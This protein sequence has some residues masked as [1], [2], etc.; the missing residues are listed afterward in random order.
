MNKELKILDNLKKIILSMGI[1]SKIKHRKDENTVI[2]DIETEEAGLVIGPKGEHLAAIQHVLQIICYK[3]DFLVDDIRIVID[4][5]S[6]KQKKTE[7]IKNLAQKIADRVKKTGKAEVLLPMNAYERR[8]FHLEIAKDGSI[9]TES[10]G[11]DPQRRI[12]VRV[13]K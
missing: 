6:Y 4:V 11:I 9:H 10:I 13:K 3:K 2:Y 1:E 12:V 5:N 7:K 8:I